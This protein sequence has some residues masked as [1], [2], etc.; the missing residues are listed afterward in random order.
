M[1]TNYQDKDRVIEYLSV[2]RDA[3]VNKPPQES[4]EELIEAC[5]GLLLYLQDKNAELTPEQI[6]EAVEKIPFVDTEIVVKLKNK[7]KK[8]NKF[9]LLLIAAI[10]PIILTILT[11]M[12]M[13]DIDWSYSKILKELFDGVD[14][15]PIGEII[16]FDNEE[17]VKINENLYKTPEEF[18]KAYNLN[19]LVPSDSFAK[20]KL[21]S[22]SYMCYPTGD[23]IEFRF[24]DK[25]LT[26]TVCMNNNLETELNNINSTQ[27]SINNIDCYIVDFSDIGHYQVYF[28]YNGY[29][30]RINHSD[31][32]VIIDLIENM[33]EIE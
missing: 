22:I 25:N 13:A 17:I 30:Y 16:N 2:I 14:K 28:N 4:D 21:I 32:D 7:N 10:I 11:I 5:V 3:E 33:E 27:T 24:D 23:E 19:V 18:I 6:S 20:A 9:K 8:V 26:Y 15:T 31:L 1:D 29:T 12:A